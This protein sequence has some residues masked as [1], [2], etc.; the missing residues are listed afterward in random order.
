MRYYAARNA[1]AHT[2]AHT[3]SLPAP[4]PGADL[5]IVPAT[6][7]MRTSLQQIRT[8]AHQ[9]TLLWLETANAH[10]APPAGWQHVQR[11]NLPLPLPGL[12]AQIDTCLERFSSQPLTLSVTWQLDMQKLALTSRQSSV[13]D[14][15]LTEKEA[16][17]L[18][19]LLQHRPDELSREQLLHDVWGYGDNVDTHTLETHIYRLRSKL[20]A[21]LPAGDGIVT[22]GDGYRFHIADPH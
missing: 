4:L 9:P 17:L 13:P 5:L 3:D 6:D 7:A 10:A 19:L 15:H 16:A 8:A 14:I 1:P 11:I 20:S 12:A 21:H 22:T 2:L 18:K